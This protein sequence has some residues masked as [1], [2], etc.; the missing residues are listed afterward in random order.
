MWA[1]RVLD[2]SGQARII[3]CGYFLPKSFT[4]V[5]ER[6]SELPSRNTGL[7]ALPSTLP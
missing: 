6:R 7:T 3:L 1:T 2:T 4:E 5:A